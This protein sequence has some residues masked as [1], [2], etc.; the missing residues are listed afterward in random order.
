MTWPEFLY[1]MPA[2]W[3]G[4]FLISEQAMRLIRERR[5]EKLLSGQPW[6]EEELAKCQVFHHLHRD[7]YEVEGKP[8]LARFVWNN[9]AWKPVEFKDDTPELRNQILGL[10]K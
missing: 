10:T 2:E 7:W 5:L 8:Y 6:N 1:E 4:G 3:G 9:G